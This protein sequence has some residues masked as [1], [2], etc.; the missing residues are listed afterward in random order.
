MDCY[1]DSCTD[2]NSDSDMDDEQK[3]MNELVDKEMNILPAENYYD[4]QLFDP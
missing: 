3:Q 1:I 4:M 2:S